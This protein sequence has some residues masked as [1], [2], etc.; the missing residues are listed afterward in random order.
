MSDIFEAIAD[1]SRR[2]LLEFLAT[3]LRTNPPGELS[4]SE[5]VAKAKL[6]Q[7]TVSK[8]LKVLREAEL[9][10]VRQIGQKSMYRVTPQAFVQLQQWLAAFTPDSES[11]GLPDWLG[12]RLESAGEWIASRVRVETDS[13]QLGLAL[14]RKLAEAREEAAT[15]TKDFATLAKSR[16]DEF[17]A[18]LRNDDRDEGI[19]R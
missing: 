15:G 4:V 18:E 16:I 10:A 1:P 5:L 6:G 8:H 7:P 13:R 2:Q 19:P 9:V 3:E 11:G 12:N 17:L 14:G